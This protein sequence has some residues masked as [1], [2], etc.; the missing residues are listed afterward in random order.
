SRFRRTG[1][2]CRRSTSCR[3]GGSTATRRCSAGSKRPGPRGRAAT[4]RPVRRPRADVGSSRLAASPSDH[5][6]AAPSSPD[7]CGFPSVGVAVATTLSTP[8]FD[9]VLAADRRIRPHLRP[10]LT[11]T[12]PALSALVGTETW[13]KHE[14]HQP[15]GAFKIRGGVNLVSDLSDAERGSGVVTA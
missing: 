11:A 4:G 14:N 8:T 2:A 1:S 7:R 6:R 5:D 15:T 10:T 13:L 12:Y 3:S 9:D